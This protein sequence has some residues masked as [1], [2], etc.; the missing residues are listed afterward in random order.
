VFRLPA[1]DHLTVGLTGTLV[2]LSW[3]WG[4]TGRVHVRYL[5]SPQR[6]WEEKP[7]A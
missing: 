1:L 4:G 3:A 6:L 7:R 2:S 5:R